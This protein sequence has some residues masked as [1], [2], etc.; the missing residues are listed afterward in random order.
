MA[1]III[2]IIITCFVFLYGL[3]IGIVNQLQSPSLT[4]TVFTALIAMQTFH[5]HQ[6]AMARW[7]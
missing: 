5:V 2:L 1:I 3:G 7:G 6:V 4:P